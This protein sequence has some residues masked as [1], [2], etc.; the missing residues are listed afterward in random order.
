MRAGV[1]VLLME[2]VVLVVAVLALAWANGAN[3]TGKPTASL[4][5]WS[6]G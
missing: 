1:G 2:V 5:A 6:L 4:L 3:D